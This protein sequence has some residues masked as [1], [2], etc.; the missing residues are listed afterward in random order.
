MF[1]KSQSVDLRDLPIDV[2]TQSI[3]PDHF[4]IP[5]LIKVFHASRWMATLK[6]RSSKDQEHLTDTEI[7]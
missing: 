1:K 6:S 4:Q 3:F 7:L 5:Q 2:K